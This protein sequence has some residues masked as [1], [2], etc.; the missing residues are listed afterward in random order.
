MNGDRPTRTVAWRRLET[1][2]RTVIQAPGWNVGLV[3]RPI[4]EVARAGAAADVRWLPSRLSRFAADPFGIEVD[5]VAHVFFEDFDRWHGRGTIAHAAIGADGQMTAPE[6]VLDPGCHAS[7]P[8][9][10]QADGAVWMLPETADLGELRLYRATDFPRTWHLETVLLHDQV[11]DPTVVRH[12]GRWW[13]FGTTRGRG[14]DRALR[15]WHASELTGPWRVHDLDPVKVDPASA[16]PAGTLFQLDGRLVRPAQDS[17]ERYGGRVVLN[18]IQVLT[19][20][21]YAERAV[22]SLEPGSGSPYPDGLHTLSAIGS[23]TLIDGNRTRFAPE[24]VVGTIRARL[25]ADRR[26]AGGAATARQR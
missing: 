11:S 19:P 14:V 15:C 25:G 24:A 23:R 4:D 22:G 2:L 3:D 9:V 16:R 17:S 20:T 18:E 13:L 1:G 12:D 21:R 7:Y 26:C 10:L 8:F 6:L 5:G